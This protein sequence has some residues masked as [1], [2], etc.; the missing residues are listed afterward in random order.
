MLKVNFPRFT[1]M[2]EYFFK[3]NEKETRTRSM[4]AEKN[5]D[6]LFSFG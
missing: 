4:E 5:C 2:F 1:A 6:I 3:V